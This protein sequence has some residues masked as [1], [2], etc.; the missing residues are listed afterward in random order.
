MVGAARG[1]AVAYT[2]ATR[3]GRPEMSERRPLFVERRFP[4]PDLFSVDRPS[5]RLGCVVVRPASRS[6]EHSSSR[7][8]AVE[9]MAAD[10]GHRCDRLS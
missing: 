3:L 5:K 8:G 6:V 1:P 4:A 2:V 10:A 9:A 7:W